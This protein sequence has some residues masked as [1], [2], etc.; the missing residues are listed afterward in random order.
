MMAEPISTD[1]DTEVPTFPDATGR[2]P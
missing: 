2:C 1:T